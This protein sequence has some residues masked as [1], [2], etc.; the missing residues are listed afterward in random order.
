MVWRHPR[1]RALNWSGRRA[2]G[3]PTRRAKDRGGGISKIS[4]TCSVYACQGARRLTDSLLGHFPGKVKMEPV[5]KMEARLGLVKAAGGNY[6]RA[7]ERQRL[8]SAPG[9]SG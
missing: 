3:R 1:W 6:S 9:D 2:A 4:Y 5:L 8:S 7:H